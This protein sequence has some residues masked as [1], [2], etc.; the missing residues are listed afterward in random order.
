MW[1]VRNAMHQYLQH[2]HTEENKVP[3]FGNNK[4]VNLQQLLYQG[5]YLLLPL[6]SVSITIFATVKMCLFSIFWGISPGTSLWEKKMTEPCS[7][8]EREHCYETEGS[9][10]SAKLLD[11]LFKQRLG[12]AKTGEV[13]N[14]YD[15]LFTT[16]SHVYVLK[17][18]LISVVWYFDVFICSFS[19]Y[20][21]I[22]RKNSP[23]FLLFTI[24][25]VFTWFMENGWLCINC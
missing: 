20:I 21:Q 10:K 12:W 3:I 25:S 23:Y 18:D 7:W 9:H 16:K 19:K 24:A 13:M 8:A 4:E 14:T 17:T 15:L 5:V 1:K 6:K 22:Q 11:Y 2:F